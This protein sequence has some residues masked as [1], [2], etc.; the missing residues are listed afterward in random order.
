MN[1]ILALLFGSGTVGV[2]PNVSFLISLWPLVLA[3]ATSVC[4]FSSIFYLL[5]QRLR[6]SASLCIASILLAI[7]FVANSLLVTPPSWQVMLAAY[8]NT[9][10]PLRLV[11]QQDIAKSWLFAENILV[12]DWYLI[13]RRWGVCHELWPQNGCAH[14]PA[15]REAQGIARELLTDVA[16]GRS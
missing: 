7:V 13:S 11:R 15:K 12:L 2:L 16:R 5:K 6:V 3:L 10:P 14:A 4:F 1:L 8:Q 9:P